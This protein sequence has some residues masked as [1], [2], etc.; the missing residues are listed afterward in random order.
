VS[1]APKITFFGLGVR[2]SISQY[3]V[4]FPVDIAAGI[5]WN[6]IKFGD[7]IDMK[8]FSFG[9]QASRSFSVLELY[10]GLAYEKSSLD[11]SYVSTA[12][13]AANVG[14]TLDGVNKFRATVGLGLNL[15]ILH[16][17]GDVNV[18]SITN[19]SAGLGFGF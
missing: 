15:A 13:G 1:G 11:L 10:G 12:P 16:L 2:H 19:F 18:G 7:L 6:T 14:L 5:F 8:S 17:Y 9:A 4:E 3:L